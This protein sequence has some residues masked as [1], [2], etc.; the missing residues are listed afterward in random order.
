MPASMFQR[1]RIQLTTIS[2]MNNL[3][4]FQERHLIANQE[5][6]LL[7][8]EPTDKQPVINK[9]Q[10]FICFVLKKNSKSQNSIL[11]SKLYLYLVPNTLNMYSL[12]IYQCNSSL[13]PAVTL[14]WNGRKKT[15]NG[16]LL[17]CL[18]VLIYQ[19]SRPTDT[20]L[21]VDFNEVVY[22]SIGLCILKYLQ[23][24]S[25]YVSSNCLNRSDMNQTW[26]TKTLKEIKIV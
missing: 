15:V 24:I 23:R 12:R 7:L 21:L 9:F 6:S 20:I 26:T 4:A 16:P 13:L 1:V 3:N 17:Y 5:M 18:L 8:T 10:C 11:N 2:L 25:C 19:E 22:Q 14:F